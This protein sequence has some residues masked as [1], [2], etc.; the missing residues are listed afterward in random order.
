MKFLYY[1]LGS[2][3]IFV[4]VNAAIAGVMMILDPSGASMGFSV[5]MLAKSPFS[6][7]LIPAIILFV[8]NGLGSFVGAFLALKRNLYASFGGLLLGGILCGWILFQVMWIEHSF[9]HTAIF[10]LGCIEMILSLLIIR[11]AVKKRLIRQ[12]IKREI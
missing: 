1:S 3:Q 7:F 2:L 9:L 11:T 5:E 6:N 8:V 12:G 4:G 10:V